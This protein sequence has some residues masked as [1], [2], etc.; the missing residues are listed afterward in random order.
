LQG[1]GCGDG[2][3]RRSTGRGLR[4]SGSCLRALVPR[5]AERRGGAHGEKNNQRHHYDDGAQNDLPDELH[6]A[7]AP[8]S[9][10]G[11]PFSSVFGSVLISP[12]LHPVR[13]VYY[14]PG[15]SGSVS[16]ANIFGAYYFGVVARQANVNVTGSSIHDIGDSPLSGAQHGNAIYYATVDSGSATAQPTCTSGA[17]CGT[18]SGNTVDNYQKNGIVANC[19]GTTVKVTNNT[20][21]GEGPV[22]YIAQNG[23]RIGYGAMANVTGNTVSGN[24]YTGPGG[25]SSGRILAVGGPCFG[26]GL[27]STVE[28][29]IT[30]NTLT[31]NDVG[32]WLFNADAPRLCR[33]DEPHEQLG[34]AEHHLQRRSHQ[35][36]RLQPSSAVWLPGRDR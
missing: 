12:T 3:R 13:A 2:G 32:V 5:W 19:T 24:A 8:E 6:W 16:G 28:L 26:A 31:N 9:A 22:I 21:T 23:I 35:H 17:T 15:T 14:G 34:Q 27:P 33:P 18:I 1:W 11:G 25:V 10:S 29:N 36:D 20:V 30:K 7:A 4:R